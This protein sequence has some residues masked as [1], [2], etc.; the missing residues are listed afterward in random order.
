MI[1]SRCIFRAFSYLGL[2]SFFFTA[3]G[4]YA[5]GFNLF[6]LAISNRVLRRH[7]LN[8]SIIQLN[9]QKSK[10]YKFHNMSW[11]L[12]Y[13]IKL[14]I[15]EYVFF[16]K[17]VW[18]LSPLK[19]WVRTSFMARCTRYNIMWYSLSVPCDRS[20]VSTTNKTDRHD[21]IEMLLTVGVCFVYMPRLCWK[22]KLTWPHHFTQRGCLGKTN[23]FFNTYSLLNKLLL[24]NNIISIW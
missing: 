8:I 20:V 1:N 13:V 3:A 17:N 5:W 19:L 4:V 18:C 14:Y 24:C 23:L 11:S 9:S 7:Y 2:I 12:F 21:I 6:T 15:A 22:N 10:N 16:P